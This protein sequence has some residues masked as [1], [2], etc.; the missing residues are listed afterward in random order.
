MQIIRYAE[1]VVDE[2]FSTM[3]FIKPVKK[4]LL[5]IKAGDNIPG[6]K[7]ISGIIGLGGSIS[8]S[9]MLHF[10]KGGALKATSSMLSEN[11]TEIDSDVIDAVGEITNMVAGGIKTELAKTGIELDQGLPIVVSGDNFNINCI[12]QNDSIV[13]PFMLGS[14]NFF[15]ELNFKN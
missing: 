13:M 1:K 5:H 9:I 6:K 7:D 10:E 8:T 11:Y 3:V 14:Y 12:N 2:V 4:M 15:L